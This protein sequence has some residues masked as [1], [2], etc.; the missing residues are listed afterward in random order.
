MG[1]SIFRLGPLFGGSR[2]KDVLH[3]ILSDKQV[4]VAG[5][6]QYSYVN[7]KWVSEEI[8]RLIQNRFSGLVEIGAKNSISLNDLMKRFN[9][10]SNFTGKND[11]QV[12]KKKYN[13]PDV[14]EVIEFAEHEFKNIS[15]WKY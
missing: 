7:V 12:P 11:T 15:K 6:T 3:D 4:Y 8:V 13:G 5:D 14:S 2:K 10:K 9:S 1:A